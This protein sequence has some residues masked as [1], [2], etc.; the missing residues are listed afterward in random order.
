MVQ[1][2]IGDKLMTDNR[3]TDRQTDR[4]AD[5]QTDRQ[6]DIFKLTP[7]HMRNFF[8]LQMGGRTNGGKVIPP[9]SQGDEMKIRN[10]STACFYTTHY[11][12]SKND[13]LKF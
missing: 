10:Y 12:A 5:R 6:A 13:K 3:Q 9:C 8:F 4:Q 1:K 11:C 7:I 2:I